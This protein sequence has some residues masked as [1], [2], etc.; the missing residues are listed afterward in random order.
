[1]GKG[2]VEDGGP[3]GPNPGPAAAMTPAG[4]AGTRE[5]FPPGGIPIGTAFIGIAPT[6]IA[7]IGTAIAPTG[8]PLGPRMI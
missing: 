8:I 1:M 2:V 6:G 4:L 5:A 3:R 7:L